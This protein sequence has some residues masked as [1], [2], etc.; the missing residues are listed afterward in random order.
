[1]AGR[2]N[3]AAPSTKE[4]L[5]AIK[6]LQSYTLL[7]AD[8]LRGVPSC[9]RRLMC[10]GLK[11]KKVTWI[12]ATNSLDEAKAIVRESHKKSPHDCLIFVPSTGVKIRLRK[13]DE[14]A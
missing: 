7:S 12:S 10:S 14:L 13:D 6:P 4:V 11:R 2:G 1:M 5:L 8:I 3:L 9:L